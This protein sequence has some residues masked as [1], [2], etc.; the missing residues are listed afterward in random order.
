MDGLSRDLRWLAWPHGSGRFRARANVVRSSVRRSR[1][2]TSCGAQEPCGHAGLSHRLSWKARPLPNPSPLILLLRSGVEDLG[3]PATST[4]GINYDAPS[5]LADPS[6]RIG[7]GGWMAFRATCDGSHGR[8]AQ[9][10]PERGR[11]LFEVPFDG[12]GTEQ[13]VEPRSHAVMHV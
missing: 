5:E 3:R 1:N 10:A 6:P 8:M 11:T 12:V 7:M 13:V 4:A 9:V 2:G